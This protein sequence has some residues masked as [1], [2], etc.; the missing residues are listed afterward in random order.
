MWVGIGI[1][2]LLMGIY[3]ITVRRLDGLRNLGFIYE[4][5][6][7]GTIDS[8]GNVERTFARIVGVT[9]ILFAN[10][11]LLITSFEG[12]FFVLLPLGICLIAGFYHLCHSKL[13]ALRGTELLGTY[14]KPA[15]EERGYYYRLWFRITGSGLITLSMLWLALG[16]FYFEYGP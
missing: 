16:L 13:G 6:R 10:F 14:F 12:P 9:L 11:W 3:G 2:S 15:T 5:S 7:V 1:I 8:P 4:K